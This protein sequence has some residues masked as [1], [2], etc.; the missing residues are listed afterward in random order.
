ML[1]RVLLWLFLSLRAAKNR[2]IAL[3]AD[4][5]PSRRNLP[6]FGGGGNIYRPPRKTLRYGQIRASFF[7]QFLKIFA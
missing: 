7:K 6:F 2:K 1:K 3:W 5:G 4:L